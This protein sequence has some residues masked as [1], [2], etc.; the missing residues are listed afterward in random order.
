MQWTTGNMDREVFKLCQLLIMIFT[1]TL[2]LRLCEVDYVSLNMYIVT[3][4]NG[5]FSF[6]GGNEVAFCHNLG[7]SCLC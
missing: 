5:Y 2:L 7:T 1:F 6:R 3:V 4:S